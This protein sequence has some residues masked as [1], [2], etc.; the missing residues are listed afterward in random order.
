MKINNV[1]LQDIDILDLEV[2][3]KWE[4]ALESV[5]GVTKSI[6]GM[7][8]SETIKTQCNA[9]FEVFNTLFG[10]GTDKRV[11][12]DRVN[13]MMCLKAFEE[14]VTQVKSQSAEVEKMASKYSPNRVQRRSKK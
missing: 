10:E 9:I 12:G 11:F 1:E 13:L 5:E 6:E 14:L 3:E 8:I 2:A 4:Q 7:K